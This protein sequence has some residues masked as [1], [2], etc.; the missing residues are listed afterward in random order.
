[1]NRPEADIGEFESRDTDAY[2][3]ADAIPSTLIE[4]MAH[5]AKDFVPET[6]AAVEYIN[7]WLEE[8]KPPPGTPIV[9]GV[10]SCAFEVEGQTF[11]A[12]AQ[13][14]RFFLLKRMQAE[15]DA[16]PRS[17][18]VDIDRLLEQANMRELLTYRLDREIGWQDNLEVWL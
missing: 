15:Y 4:L 3:D 12:L 7:Q 5:I 14:Y 8:K 18:Q 6:A 2:I 9:R 16:V 17:T 1:M 10:G 11:K 13:P